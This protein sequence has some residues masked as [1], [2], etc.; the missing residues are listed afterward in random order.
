MDRKPLA[1]DFRYVVRVVVRDGHYT[2][3]CRTLTARGSALKG[4][5]LAGLDE[6]IVGGRL[7]PAA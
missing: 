3:G 6:A 4:T 5:G 7:T 2:G 1:R